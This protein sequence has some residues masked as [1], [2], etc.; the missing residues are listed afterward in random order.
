MGC[1]SRAAAVPAHQQ[2]VSRT[3]ALIDKIC[4]LAEL[5]LNILQGF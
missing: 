1:V 3:Q 2:F 5:R 4:C